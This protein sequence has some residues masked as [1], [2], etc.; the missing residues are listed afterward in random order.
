MQYY[1]ILI[2]MATVKN[3]TKAENSKDVE[4]LELLYIYDGNVELYRH[5]R[6]QYDSSSKNQVYDVYLLC[7]MHLLSFKIFIFVSFRK[8]LKVELP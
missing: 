7:E 1:L 4:K 3:K 5:Y 6:K 2:R 8:K